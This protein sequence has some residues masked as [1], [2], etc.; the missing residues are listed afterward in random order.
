M[1]LTFIFYVGPAPPPGPGLCQPCDISSQCGALAQYEDMPSNSL[2]ALLL[3]SASV[4]FQPLQCNAGV[5]LPESFTESETLCQLI[6]PAH[7]GEHSSPESND[8]LGGA[9]KLLTVWQT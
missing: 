3:G 6:L 2:A 7:T 1:D 4:S 8:S 9:R 5:C